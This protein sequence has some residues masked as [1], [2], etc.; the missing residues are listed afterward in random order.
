MLVFVIGFIEVM[1]FFA[2]SYIGAWALAGECCSECSIP[3]GHW[4]VGLFH[5]QFVNWR[6]RLVYAKINH[7]KERKNE[8][9]QKDARIAGLLYLIYIVVHVFGRCAWSF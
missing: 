1:A 8:Y 9:K 2:S 3:G 6:E 5:I 7:N 4:P